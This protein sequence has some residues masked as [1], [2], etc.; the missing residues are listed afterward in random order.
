MHYEHSITS[1]SWIPS[2]AIAGATR[3]PFDAGATHYDPPP[4]DRLGDLERLKASDRFRFAN[5]LAAW[6][7][8]DGSGT[9]T[10]VGYTGASMIGSTTVRLGSHSHRFQAVAFPDIRREPQR[11]DGWVRFVQTGGGRTGL[12]APRGVRRAPFVKWQAPL[13]WTTLSLTLYAD[14]RA[15]GALIGASPFPRH[16]VYDHCPAESRHTGEAAFDPD[17]REPTAREL[18]RKG[19]GFV[20]S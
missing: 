1:L 18:Q 14:G 2:E 5:R 4:L 19:G 7:E 17:R 6:I 20:A 11:G 3:P 10:D 8:V 9:I 15:Q 13:A 16:W 12:P